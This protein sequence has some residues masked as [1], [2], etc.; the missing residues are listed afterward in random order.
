MSWGYYRSTRRRRRHYSAAA[1][2]V[3]VALLGLLAGVVLGG[4]P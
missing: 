3:G 1:L 4:V 2:F